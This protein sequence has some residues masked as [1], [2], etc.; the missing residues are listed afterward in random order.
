MPAALPGYRREVSALW[1]AIPTGLGVLLWL[2][3]DQFILLILGGLMGLALGFG[4][5]SNRGGK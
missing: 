1:F 4:F 5:Q 2:A 3:T